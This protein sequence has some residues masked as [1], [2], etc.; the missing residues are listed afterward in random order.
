MRALLR[1]LAPALAWAA[2]VIYIGGRSSVPA[3]RVD[4]PLDK[5]AHFAMYGILG[6]LAGRAARQTWHRLGWGWFVAGG[7]ILGA[8][9]EL[10]QYFIPSRSS[11]PMDWLA[12]AAGYLIGFWLVYRG[13]ARAHGRGRG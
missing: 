9:D 4:L 5:V 6:L 13:V 3:P 2:F 7:L 8:L 1:A 11:D 10:Q 12:D